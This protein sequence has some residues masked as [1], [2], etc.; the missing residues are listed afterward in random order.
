MIRARLYTAIL[1]LVACAGGCA[2]E[3]A[4][5]P[6]AETDSSAAASPA[7][8]DTTMPVDTLTTAQRNRI[9]PRLQQLLT[10]KAR[11]YR[12][13]PVG[14][15]DG[16]PI[17]SVTIRSSDAEAFREAGL[18]VTSVQGDIITARLTVEEIR[19]AATVPSVQ[20]IRAAGEVQPQ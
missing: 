10:S 14:T 4:S 13:E 16:T 5:S 20:A 12:V 1:L 19:R 18:S 15:R 6:S 11:P 3:Q 8:A 7:A 2:G 9:G 17:Y